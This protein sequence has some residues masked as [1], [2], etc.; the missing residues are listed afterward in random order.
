MCCIYSVITILQMSGRIFNV[1]D[2]LNDYVLMTI[3]SES[4]E[5]LLKE[6]EK[7]V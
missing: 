3:N 5:K 4:V 6:V 1:L 2:Y 7:K